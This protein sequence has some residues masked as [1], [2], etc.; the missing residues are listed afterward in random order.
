VLGVAADLGDRILTAVIPREHLP[1]IRLE[2][3]TRA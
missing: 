3:M 1:Y 2:F